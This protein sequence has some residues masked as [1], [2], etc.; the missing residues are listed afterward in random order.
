MSGSGRAMNLLIGGWQTQQHTQLQRRSPVDA[1]IGECGQIEDTGPCRPNLVNGQSFDVGPKKVNGQWYEFT[2]VAPLAYNVGPAEAGVDSC[3]LGSADIRTRSRFLL[4]ARSAMP[5][6]TLPR[7]AR[8][9][10]RHG[11]LEDLRNHRAHQGAV[12]LRCLQRVQPSGVLG[13][14]SNQGNTCVDCGGNAG[15]ITDIEA[16]SSPGSPTGMRQ[17]QFGLR[18]T[19]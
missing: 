16:D 9:L 13:F 5:A 7:S 2:P 11:A 8:V 10:L 4:A 19:F 3:T 15:Q 14:N 1:S 18:V 6:S 17:L 12:P